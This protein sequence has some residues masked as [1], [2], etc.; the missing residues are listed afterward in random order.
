MREGTDDAAGQLEAKPGRRPVRNEASGSLTTSWHGVAL[1]LL[2][3][4]AL[5]VPDECALLVADLH[6]GKPGAFRLFGSPVPEEV[7]D[8]DLQRLSYAISLTNARRLI[9]LGDLFHSRHGRGALTPVL[10]TWR[11]AHPELEVTLVRGNHDRSAGDPPA[12]L[13]LEVVDGPAALGPFD[14]VHEPPVVAP[15][16][17][18]IGAH[19]HPAVSLRSPIGRMRSTCFWL[20]RDLCVLPAFGTFT[21]TRIVKP[22]R[23]DRVFVVGDSVVVA[24]GPE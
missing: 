7:T 16:R 6:L 23:D 11:G 21:G 8:V 10:E 19:V 1:Q 14:L 15:T 4:R 2:P 24:A 18:T 17:P 13:G 22:A 3:Q 5:Y 20:A 12:S 9:V